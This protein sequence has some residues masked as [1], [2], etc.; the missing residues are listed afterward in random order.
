[1][2]N[3]VLSVVSEAALTALARETGFIER[4]RKL[5]PKNW[6]L[7]LLF[8][9][10]QQKKTSLEDFACDFLSHQGEIVS[11]VAFH[12]KFNRRAVSFL[13]QILQRFISS[14]LEPSLKHSFS[15]VLVR[16]STKF[17]LPNTCKDDYPGFGKP[18]KASSV[19]N[20]Q[21]EYEL[22]SHQWQEVSLGSVRINDQK[23]AQ[24]STDI[25]RENDLILRDL[26]YINLKT[27][28]QII[29]A[30]AFF[31]SRLPAHPL[32]FLSSGEP[33]NWKKINAHIKKHKLKRYV[34]EVKIGD[35]ERIPV[36][37]VL[38]PVSEKLK[39][40]RIKKAKKKSKRRNVK[41]L[42]DLYKMRQGYNLFIT[43]T[44]PEQI[45]DHEVSAVYRLRWQIELMFRTWKSEL[46]VDKV[47]TKKSERVECE[48]LAKMIWMIIHNRMLQL[49]DA[50]LTETIG[51]RQISPEKFFKRAKLLNAMTRKWMDG[52]LSLILW[53]KKVYIPIIKCA[54]QQIRED[55][56]NYTQVIKHVLS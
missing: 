38:E 11:D 1:M 6:L 54:R 24:D 27:I 8:C 53:A 48:V 42:T 5:T 50:H 32:V 17:L 20:I 56:R 26:G 33:F 19:M 10:H 45:P 39:A 34:V 13:K 7:T 9:Q 15:R 4:V 18:D 23:D 52:E 16:D 49:A 37:L 41:G 47:R 22:L 44:V 28:G 3:S 36:R 21:Y 43:N 51:H 55:R 14:P 31:V 25:A 30:K 40:H 46:N 29:D 12:K 35:K 2:E